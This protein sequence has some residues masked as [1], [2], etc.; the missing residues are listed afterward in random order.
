MMPKKYEFLLLDLDGTLYDFDRAEEKALT[1]LLTS[2]G[3]KNCS[4]QD[5]EAYHFYNDACWKALERGEI[6]KERLKAKRFEDFLAY[7][8]WDYDPILA[9]EEY[10]ENLSHNGFLLEG[11]ESLLKALSQR[12]RLYAITNGIEK[13]QLG[14]W[15]A[16]GIGRYFQNMFVSDAIGVAKPHIGY[17]EYVFARIEG[18]DRD[19]ALLIGDSLSSDIRGGLN[20]QV[21]TLWYNPRHLAKPSDMAITYEFDDLRRIQEFLCH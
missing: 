18:F 16:S 12:Y 9:G 2:W 19:K 11:A 14:R 5:V 15:A 6:T 17:F 13:V 20:A 8:H 3:L 4:A 1:D 21:D 10:A 7:L